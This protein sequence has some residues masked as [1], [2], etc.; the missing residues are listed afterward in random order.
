MSTIK[1]LCKITGLS[2]GT[3]SNYLNGKKIK[4][5][6][7]EK[8]EQAI[9]ETSFIPSNLGRYLKSGKSKTIGIIASDI[10]APYVS[11]AISV[12]ERNLS[13][14]GYR[15][16]FCNSHDNV[17]NEKEN[18]NFMIQQSVS[19]IVIFPIHY[20]KQ[21]LEN[22][23]KSKIPLVMCDSEPA[24]SSYECSCINY[25]NRRLAYEA[26]ELMIRSG[27]KNIAC[28]LGR[29]DHFSSATRV[30]GYYEA[31]MNHNIDCSESNIY[32]CNFN[33]QESYQAT[34]KMLQ[35]S[36]ITACL[37][38]SNN[39]LL[40]FLEALD[41]VGKPLH[42]DISYVTFSHE[43]YYDILPIKPTYILH[44]F[45]SF[46]KKTLKAIEDVVFSETLP[47]PEKLIAT[48]TLVL[49]DS[50]KLRS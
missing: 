50:H 11:A 23:F 8:I 33:N 34:V 41:K 6:N 21:S 43:D 40:G 22:V 19:A 37:I 17:L 7:A 26:T 5:E 20:Q 35:N 39:M 31:L 27:H 42:K 15:I 13:E 47:Q 32:Y 24:N 48:S 3:V 25:D 30:A 18:L 44:D 46:G 38:A 4:P 45:Q 28:I 16:F 1:D 10:S 36:N 29:A 2:L 49:G 14:K 9:Q 12:L